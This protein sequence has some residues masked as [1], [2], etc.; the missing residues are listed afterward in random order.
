MAISVEDLMA[1]ARLH[2]ESLS[3]AEARD[4]ISAGAILIDTRCSADR[5]AEGVVPGS[6]QHHRT[7]LEWRLDPESESHDR[8]VADRSLRHIIMCNDGYSSLLAAG[9]LAR[10][11]FERIGHLDG[12]YRGWKAAGLPAQS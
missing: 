4:A 5:E 11:G 8:A 1:D 3:P 9:N 12:G 2:V 7:V 6:V 10:M